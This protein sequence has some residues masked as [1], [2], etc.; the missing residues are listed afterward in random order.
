MGLRFIL[1]LI[2]IL[3]QT[4]SQTIGAGFLLREINS[5]QN[6]IADIVLM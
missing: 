4:G 6:R 5:P 3:L 2:S 1:S